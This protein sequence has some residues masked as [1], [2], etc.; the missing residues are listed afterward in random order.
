MSIDFHDESECECECEIWL[1]HNMLPHQKK[2]F[3]TDSNSN[4]KI[5]LK[6][7]NSPRRRC[8]ISSGCIASKNSNTIMYIPRDMPFNAGKMLLRLPLAF[9]I[10]TH[11]HTHTSIYVHYGWNE[12]RQRIPIFVRSMAI[13]IR[14]VFSIHFI[15]IEFGVSGEKRMSEYFGFSSSSTCVW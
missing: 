4:L 7:S 11:I 10:S 13:P 15:Y 8:V 2:E 3:N 1:A 9:Y 12:I 5:S 14:F 6:F